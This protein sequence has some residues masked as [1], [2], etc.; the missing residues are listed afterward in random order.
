[1]DSTI[2]LDNNISDTSHE[3]DTK[4]NNSSKW[5]VFGRK[6]PKSEIVF[7]VQVILVYIV[8]I[9]SIANLTIGR[10]DEKLWIT[11]LSSSIG[12]LLPNPSLNKNY[13]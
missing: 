3:T 13:V 10:T 5:H 12:Y 9:V 1:M 2:R 8:V 7:F 6:F 4:S 11:L